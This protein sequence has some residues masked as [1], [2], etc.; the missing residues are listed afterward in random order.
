MLASSPVFQG[1]ERTLAM[2]MTRLTVFLVGLLAPLAMPQGVATASPLTYDYSGTFDT[3]P[4]TGT[5]YTGTF[6]YDTA[7]SPNLQTNIP[8]TFSLFDNYDTKQIEAHPSGLPMFTLVDGRQ[9]GGF[10][11]HVSILHFVSPELDQPLPLIQS[12]SV[13]FSP[14]PNFQVV[15][16]DNDTLVEL[17]PVPEP[18]TLLLLATGLT[19]VLGTRLRRRA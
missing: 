1:P 6:T 19:G 13:F 14:D 4:L 10:S 8:L 3:G 15:N 5:A 12:A 2:K 16:I 18:G 7:G 11:L 17:A 9:T